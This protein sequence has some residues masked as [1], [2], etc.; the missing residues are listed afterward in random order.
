MN[1]YF[2]VCTT[3]L[4]QK[5][6][7]A[8]FIF[9]REF[10]ELYELLQI[11]FRNQKRDIG[12][13]RWDTWKVNVVR[14]VSILSLRNLLKSGINL[15]LKPGCVRTRTHC[16]LIYARVPRGIRIAYRLTRLMVIKIF[17]CLNDP[18]SNQ[19]DPGSIFIGYGYFGDYY[20][21]F[22]FLTTMLLLYSLYS[23][24]CDVTLRPDKFNAR[25]NVQWICTMR[26]WKSAMGLS[27]F[28][29]ATKRYRFNGPI[30]ICT[31]CSELFGTDVIRCR[32]RK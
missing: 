19:C 11:I 29:C 16:M 4:S 8:D 22:C 20:F 18:G 10:C 15:Y 13:K 27:S 25:L 6:K 30:R 21:F 31:K 24:Y 23:F 26:L 14:I 12:K 17:I 1:R 5:K 3:D 28:V 2:Q 9:Q 7:T 32:C